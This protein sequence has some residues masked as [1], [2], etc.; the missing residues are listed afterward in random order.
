MKTSMLHTAWGRFAAMAAALASLLALSASAALVPASVT[1]TGSS[2]TTTILS[3]QST[4]V[5]FLADGTFTVPAGAT[6]RILV[7]G[8][9]GGGGGDC[10]PGGG[11]GGV[12]DRDSVM[13]SPGTYTVAVGVGGTGGSGT[14][15]K[16]TNGGNTSLTRNGAD[17]PLA[18]AYGGGGAGAWNNGAGLDGG[19]GGGGWGNPGQSVAG[20]GYP[21]TAQQG[22]APGGGGGAGGSPVAVNIGRGNSTQ[23]QADGGPGRASDITGTTEYYGPG[24]GSG[25][26]NG[27]AG[28]GGDQSTLATEGWIWGC[29]WSHSSAMTDEAMV[30]AGLKQQGRDGYGGGGGGSSNTHYPGGNGGSGVLILRI[31]PVQAAPEPKITVTVETTG[32]NPAVKVF[33]ASLGADA[34][35]AGVFYQTAL[36]AASLDAAATNVASAAATAGQTV[37]IPLSSY[38]AGLTFHVRVVAKNDQGVSSTPFETTFRLPDLPV[39]AAAEGGF[40]T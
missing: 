36:S 39:G 35:T 16:G 34:D 15:V 13:L 19:C 29:G 17:G 25:G 20:Q 18:L 9:G 8:G 3:D 38:P 23:R 26:F 5:K 30:A 2:V 32:V 10:A 24:G 4:V 40:L 7:V 33:L 6:A 14:G 31:D 37:S 28:W 11:G 1:T 12:I 22:D 21:A 27:L